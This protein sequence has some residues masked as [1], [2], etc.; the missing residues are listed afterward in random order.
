MFLVQRLAKNFPV[1]SRHNRNC[2]FMGMLFDKDMSVSVR[3]VHRVIGLGTC[4]KYCVIMLI[5]R[6]SIYGY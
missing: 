6:I 5:L 2:A 4:Y 1:T 3:H